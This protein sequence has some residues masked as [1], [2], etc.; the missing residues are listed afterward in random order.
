M[1]LT[2]GGG[3]RPVALQEEQ[4]ELP[5][6]DGQESLKGLIDRADGIETALIPEPVV[7]SDED[8]QEAI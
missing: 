7:E 3:D 8:P 1:G 4:T 6:E 2:E 5:L